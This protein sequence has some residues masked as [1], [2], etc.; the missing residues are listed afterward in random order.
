MNMESHSIRISFQ[1]LR[2]LI[3]FNDFSH[4]SDKYDYTEATAPSPYECHQLTAFCDACWVGQFGIAVD[5]YTPLELFNF[6]QYLV[7]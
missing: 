3:I 5:E 2:P 4:N 1:R 6:F 7:F